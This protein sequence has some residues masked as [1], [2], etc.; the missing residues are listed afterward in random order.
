MS[1]AECPV[2]SL[3]T[4]LVRGYTLYTG[5]VSLLSVSFFLAFLFMHH[6]DLAEHRTDEIVILAFFLALLVLFGVGLFFAVRLAVRFT[7]MH[8]E[9]HKLT[10]DIAHD[11]RTPL[12]RMAAAAELAASDSAS[13]H[14]LAETVGTES[15]A[16]LHLINTM[17]DISKTGQGLDHSP[18]TSLDLAALVRDV[19]DL[20]SAVAEEKRQVMTLDVPSTPL[21]FNGH[22]G[23]LRQL[24]QNLLENAIK[25]TPENG[26]VQLSLHRENSTT[27]LTVV[28]DGPGVL[29]KD[30]PHLFDRFYRG[31]ASRTLPGNGLGLALVKAIATS[32]GGGVACEALQPHG[33][34]FTV[35]LNG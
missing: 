2:P 3:K 34:R 7:R 30:L 32:Y 19:A 11:L 22:E 23:K 20:Y 28:D 12:T 24:V 10:D 5:A 25:F 16:L 1:S 14:D 8:E 4:R 27:V 33:T 17:L 35:R 18:R 31:D 9:L 13:T 21:L 29:P 6:H 15:A 26:H